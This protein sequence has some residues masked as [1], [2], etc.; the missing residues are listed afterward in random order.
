[1]A[2]PPTA[3]ADA[4]EKTA[5]LKETEILAERDLETNLVRQQVESKA[6]AVQAF[7]DKQAKGKGRGKGKETEKNDPNAPK[8]DWKATLAT[9][10]ESCTDEKLKGRLKEILEADVEELMPPAAD[11][12]SL[13]QVF[14]LT[15][16]A[17]ICSWCPPC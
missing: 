2:K 16:H 8:E 11:A 4:L 13:P 12:K 14:H 17:P 15:A 1:M 9:R 6:S 10:I 7:R 3:L 5:A